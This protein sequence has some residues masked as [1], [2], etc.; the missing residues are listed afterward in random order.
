MLHTA[1]HFQHD[2][3]VAKAHRSP[4]LL[5]RSFLV[6]RPSKSRLHATSFWGSAKYDFVC[7]SNAACAFRSC[8]CDF[9]YAS[10]PSPPPPELS[11]LPSCSKASSL[12]HLT[13][14]LLPQSYHAV[15]TRRALKARIFLK[16]S[17]QEGGKGALLPRITSSLIF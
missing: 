5:C 4:S 8:F 17:E 10:L 3:P 12:E 1:W 13:L 2:H 16:V 7:D 15:L 9:P 6:L 11:L 14:P